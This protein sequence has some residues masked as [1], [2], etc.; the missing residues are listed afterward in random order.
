MPSIQLRNL[1]KKK[2]YLAT[3]PNILLDVGKD[4][5]SVATDRDDQQDK[6]DEGHH[7]ADVPES[8][9]YKD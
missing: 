6:K 3:F 8:Y 5:E 7:G 4:H 1:S 2:L 9:I